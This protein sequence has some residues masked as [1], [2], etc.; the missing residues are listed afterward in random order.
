M[1]NND[2]GGDIGG[3]IGG[4]D[5]ATGLRTAVAFARLGGGGRSGLLVPLD[6]AASAASGRGATTP[7][8]KVVASPCG[9]TV[10][11]QVYACGGQYLATTQP[12]PFFLPDQ[13]FNQNNYTSNHDFDGHRFHPASA[14]STAPT[15][16]LASVSRVS[17]SS[18]SG[19]GRS[20]VVIVVIVLVVGG[21]SAVAM[22]LRRRRP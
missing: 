4:I 18:D 6:D 15:T 19:S 11:H 22:S 12:P 3:D 9:P 8:P 16:A 21:G 13:S 14:S 2:R 5:P 20:A 1:G 7:G 10:T 17:S